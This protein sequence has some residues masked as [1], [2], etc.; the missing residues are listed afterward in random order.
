MSGFTIKGNVTS[1]KVP[2]DWYV[3]QKSKM[4]ENVD[5]AMELMLKN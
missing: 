3:H 2:N 4:D 1:M 5:Q